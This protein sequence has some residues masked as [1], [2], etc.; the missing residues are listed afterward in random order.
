MQKPKEQWL[1]DLLKEVD[2]CVDEERLACI[3]EHRGRACISN[4]YIKKAKAVANDAK[5]IDEFLDNL[6]KR[7]AL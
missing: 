5:N 6:Q 3:L 2:G 7:C 1:V 4:N